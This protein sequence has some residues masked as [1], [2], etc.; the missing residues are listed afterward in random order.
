MTLSVIGTILYAQ[1]NSLPTG[2]E[3]EVSYA[4]VRMSSNIILTAV[5]VIP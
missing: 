5:H 4:I 2:G 1:L 3:T